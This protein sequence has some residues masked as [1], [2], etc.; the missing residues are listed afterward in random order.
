MQTRVAAM[1][2]EVQKCL[3][4]SLF[5]DSGPISWHTGTIYDRKFDENAKK[6]KWSVYE[7]AKTVIGIQA[8]LKLTKLLQITSNGTSLAI[9]LQLITV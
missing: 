9:S 2:C 6:L 1:S 7:N 5:T 4:L 3:K 8:L